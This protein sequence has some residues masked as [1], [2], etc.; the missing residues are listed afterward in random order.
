MAPVVALL[1]W[2]VVV[3]LTVV[4]RN[5]HFLRVAIVQTVAA[6]EVLASVEVLGI[7]NIRVVLEAIEIA[8][9]LVVSPCLPVGLRLLCRSG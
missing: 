5:L 4:D 2:V 1:L 7:I 3:P 6:A 8:S 9:P